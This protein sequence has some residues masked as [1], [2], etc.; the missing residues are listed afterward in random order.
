MLPDV[1]RFDLFRP[2]RYLAHQLPADQNKEQH[3]GDSAATSA[4]TNGAIDNNLML[5]DTA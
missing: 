1:A 2:V 4:V 5:F 3:G